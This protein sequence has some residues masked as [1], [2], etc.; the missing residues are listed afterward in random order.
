MPEFDVKVKASLRI[1]RFNRSRSRSEPEWQRNAKQ[2]PTVDDVFQ[3]GRLNDKCHVCGDGTK[4]FADESFGSTGRLALQTRK[5]SVRHGSHPALTRF[6]DGEL[7]VNRQ[8]L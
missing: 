2:C 1:N 4:A 6:H 5:G 3:A 7:H 8:I